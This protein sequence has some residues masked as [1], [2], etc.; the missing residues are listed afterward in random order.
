MVLM[1]LFFHIDSPK[2]DGL[3][4]RQQIQRLDPVGIFF[5][6]GRDWWLRRRGWTR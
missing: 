1:T 4:V 6:V 2:R 3:S 5:F